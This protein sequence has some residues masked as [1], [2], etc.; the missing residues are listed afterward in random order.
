MV[1]C[2]AAHR[3]GD[4]Y[5]YLEQPIGCGRIATCRDFG[6]Q[7]FRRA[8]ASRLD[9]PG[10]YNWREHHQESNVMGTIRTIRS[11]KETADSKSRDAA[12]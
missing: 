11:W 5:L 6:S 12:A 3:K 7:L 1:D 9:I 10:Q 4:D 2:V 8:I